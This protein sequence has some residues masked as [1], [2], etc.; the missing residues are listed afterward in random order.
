M[1][2]PAPSATDVHRTAPRKRLTLAQKRE[3]I[4]QLSDGATVGDMA[5]TYGCGRRTVQ[6]IQ[7]E[8]DKIFRAIEKLAC[9]TEYKSIKACKFP[10]IDKSVYE[11]V[12]IARAAKLPLSSSTIRQRAL[13]IRDVLLEKENSAEDVARLEGFSASSNWVTGFVRRHALRSVRLHGEAGSVSVGDVSAGIATLRE[14]LLHYNEEFVF[15]MD[16]TGL[17]FKLFPKKTYVLPTEDKK[18]LRGTKEMKAKARVS[19]YVCTNATG[20]LKVPMAVIGTAKNPRCF[21]K[22]PARM[23]Y[24]SQKNAW[25]DAVTFKQWFYTVFLPFVRKKTS[26]KVVLLID[27]CGPH[28][29]DLHDSRDQVKILTLPPNCTSLFQPMDM[30]VIAALKLQYKSRLLE[31][32]S[33]TIESRAALR[34]AS[35]HMQA[36]TKGLDEGHD[37]HMLDVC[38]LLYEAWESISE[39]CIARCW[40][41][42]DILPRDVQNKLTLLHGKVKK[43]SKMVDDKDISKITA[44]ISEIRLHDPCN[45]GT[46][47]LDVDEEDVL[48]WIDIESNAEVQEALVNDCLEHMDE[49][50]RQDEGQL[51]VTEQEA[52]EDLASGCSEVPSL[53]VVAQAFEGVEDLA[54]RSGVTEASKALRRAK[55]A[56]FEAYHAETRKKQRQT[57]IL[58][59]FGA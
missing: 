39:K 51:H 7:S 4:E 27:N 50:V 11:F 33:C 53:I 24:L 47:L 46:D 36:G 5:K 19:L 25:S 48:N 13:Q 17:C 42:A 23:A 1:T 58:E 6:K 44:L 14:E 2:P 16:E 3:I 18:K 57:L 40:L 10:V 8:A 56:F 28:A 26:E 52:G 54:A 38:E 9:N 31:R 21:R 32:I 55:R 30:G 29:A 22:G 49:E 37:P 45:I 20:T 34:L 41:K 15:N 35:R 43:A 59:H 12:Q